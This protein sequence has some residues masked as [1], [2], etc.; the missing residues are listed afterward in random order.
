MVALMDGQAGWGGV[1]EP[2][3]QHAPTVML[4]QTSTAVC[5]RAHM[6]NQADV[7]CMAV[8]VDG[9]IPCT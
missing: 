4:P 5:T 3:Q 6:Q 9:P 1:G 7:D 2:V 8:T